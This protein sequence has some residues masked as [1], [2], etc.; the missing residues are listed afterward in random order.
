[1]FVLSDLIPTHITI[2]F[3][4]F[5]GYSDALLPGVSARNIPAL[6]AKEKLTTKLQKCL[7][8]KLV[9]VFIN[10]YTVEIT[11]RDEKVVD[12]FV[13]TLLLAVAYDDEPTDLRYVGE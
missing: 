4:I 1:M 13:R 7:Y 12:D 3:S 6:K 11:Q 2:D 10:N 8:R 9:Q 5:A